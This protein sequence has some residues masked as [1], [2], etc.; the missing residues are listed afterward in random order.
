[1]S[2][3]D[4]APV[5]YADAP[6]IGV[7][8][9]VAP[10]GTALEVEAV[11]PWA[12]TGLPALG[13]FLLVELS[14]DE[15]LVIRVIRFLVMGSLSGA[16]GEEYLADCARQGEGP[17]EPI[18]RRM[19]RFT[20][21]AA[22]LGTIRSSTAALTF[23]VG[24]RTPVMLGCRLRRPASGALHMLCNVGLER[25]PSAAI[26]GHYALGRS[27]RSDIPV[28]F[29]VDRL[30]GRRSFVFARAGYGKSN[31]LKYLISQLYSAPPDVGL[32]ILD[33]EGE[34]ALPDA[35]GRPGLINVPALRD[36]ISLYT[37]R[38]VPA[39]YEHVR[40]G[41]ASLDLGDFSPQDIVSSFVA[42]DK[43]EIVSMNNVRMMR[44][45][46]WRKLIALLA[47]EG[48]HASDEAIA[49]VVGLRARGNDAV[50]QAIR[51]NLIPPISRMHRDG[52][53]IGRRLIAEL[54]EGRIVIVDTSLLPLEDAESLGALLLQR[55]FSHN[56]KHFTDP[57]RPSVRCLA[58]IEEAQTVLGGRSPDDRSIW[59]RWVKEGRKYG[60]GCV[61]VTQQPGAISEQIIS[62]GDNFFVMHLL[63][64]GDLRMLQRHNGYFT[65]DL[66]SFIRSEPIRGNCF[67]WS[68]PD[69]PYVLPARV[70]NFEEVTDRRPADAIAPTRVSDTRA[71]A[72]A[73]PGASRAAIPH[74]TAPTADSGQT[75]RTVRG[76]P[77]PAR[78]ASPAHAVGGSRDDGEEGRVRDFV[79]EAIAVDPRLWLYTAPPEL[80]G[81]AAPDGSGAA[82]TRTIVFSH[83]Y[84]LGTVGDRFRRNPDR[85]HAVDR[86]AWLRDELPV[87]V[88]VVL[89]ALGGT[90]G[91]AQIAG[92]YR[93][94]WIL[95][96]SAVPALGS[97]G[98]TFRG[99]VA[100]IDRSL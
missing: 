91:Y 32:L 89:T 85:I 19:L 39:A 96:A 82:G 62:Q 28:R 34:Y 67:F 8:R 72:P 51:N 81:A 61:L 84:L 31:L 57:A 16:Q 90:Q 42:R 69:Q 23:S 45:P 3:P 60:L 79:C 83:D 4:H 17:P 70:M 68:A 44:F 95:P 92:A 40:R 77:Q 43:Q 47:T 58:V 55:I 21:R 88:K 53:P 20:M 26:L 86:E 100:G 14:P 78:A 6:S 74:T 25:D 98:K 10:T 65:E 56:R 97:T 87:R 29:S 2:Q 73:P 49:E 63:N 36:R 80:E 11:V 27:V 94:V 9:G 54:A 30:K 1:M 66:L 46:E 37:N 52:A 15:A 33:P 24:E 13:E 41:E 71:T 35:E 93:R 18:L 50:L 7:L 99:D 76:V 12:P 75:R 5:L 48:H 38:A 64:D 59:V 22:V